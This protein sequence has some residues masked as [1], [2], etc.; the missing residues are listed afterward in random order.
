M[1]EPTGIKLPYIVTMDEGSGKI[2][3]IVRNWREADMLRRKRQYFVHYKFLP[4]F[5]FYGF[6]LLHMIGGLSRAATSI[7]RQLI[8]AGTLSIYRVVSRLVVFVFAMMM[9]L[10]ILASSVILTL[11]AAIFVT[12][13]FLYLT[14]NHLERLPNF[15]ELLSTLVEDLHKWQTQRSL[16]LIRRLQSAQQWLS[17]SKAQK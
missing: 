5:G 7:L 12:P 11:L 2:L 3:S 14:K 16:T 13:L 9:S 8:D 6:G 15:W 17:S 10:S 1:G 4:G